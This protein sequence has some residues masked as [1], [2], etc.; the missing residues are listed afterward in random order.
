MST[1]KKKN[2]AGRARRV[3][4]FVTK[5][6]RASAPEGTAN[7]RAAAPD[8]QPNAAGDAAPAPTARTLDLA[9]LDWAIEMASEVYCNAFA[10]LNELRTLRDPA[11]SQTLFI[12]GEPCSP[13][14]RALFD[15]QDA[16]ARKL[17]PTRDAPEVV[18]DAQHRLEQRAR[19]ALAELEAERAERQA[20]EAGR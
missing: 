3:T 7:A 5:N 15:A 20:R 9:T 11:Y 6:D 1:R 8:A 2:P 14:K 16:A 17:M 10:L 4:R 13:R 19:E 18:R 12:G